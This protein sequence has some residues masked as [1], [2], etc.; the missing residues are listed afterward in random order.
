MSAALDLDRFGKVRTLMSGGSTAAERE[1]AKTRAEAMA[2]AAGLTFAKACTKADAAKVK[3]VAPAP[4]SK[5][6]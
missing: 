5:A 1:A 6:A 2:R 4:S 3:P